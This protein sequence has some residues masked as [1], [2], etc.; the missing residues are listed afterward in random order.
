[1]ALSR[2]LTVMRSVPRLGMC[3]KSRPVMLL[4][5][6]SSQACNRSNYLT[7]RLRHTLSLWP[8]RIAASAAQAR[9]ADSAT[10]TYSIWLMSSPESDVT[11]RVKQEMAALQQRAEGADFLPHVTLVGGIAGAELSVVDKVKSLAAD[12]QVCLQ[13]LLHS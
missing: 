1:M 5:L 9:M 3:L 2:R 4:P 12:M 8:G 6:A 11:A 13:P 10:S 7:N